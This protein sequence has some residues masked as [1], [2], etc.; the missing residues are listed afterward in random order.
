[1]PDAPDASSTRDYGF[2]S[3]E[4]LTVR[5]QE[6]GG[7]LKLAASSGSGKQAA[8]PVEACVQDLRGVWTQL[9]Q[10]ALDFDPHRVES[11]CERQREL[12]LALGIMH[13]AIASVSTS[14]DKTASTMGSQLDHLARL[15][16]VRDADVLASRL[17]AAIS[18]VRHATNTL[19]ASVT[20]ASAE[21]KES[22]ELV[23]G[24]DRKIAQ[25]HARSPRDVLTRVLNR[26][27]FLERL[28]GLA[29]QS[30][31]IAGYWSVILLEL[32]HLE[33]VNKK[34]GERVGDALLFR[35]A[36]MLQD[37]CE[38][39]P[40]AAVART[41]GKEF[42]VILP[43]CPL[44]DGRRMAE[45]IRS[46]VERARW[47]CRVGTPHAIIATTLSVA[48]TEFRDGESTDELLDRAESCLEQARAAGRNT[49]AA[50]G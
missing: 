37:S 20:R 49:I 9:R 8:K 1:M 34:L 30:S 26:D 50:S 12:W 13:G 43:R 3:P 46:A 7:K 39:H 17:D 31:L 44:S 5:L 21:I 22:A 33:A 48:V 15:D 19:K 47:E 6:L 29:A 42:A 14:T 41:A 40:A 45:H 16:G 4:E 38:F 24:V 35:V 25:A 11:M 10:M 28:N 2:P 23:K 36:G 18:S 32:D 27:A